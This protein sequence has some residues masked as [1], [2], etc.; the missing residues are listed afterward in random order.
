MK[1]CKICGLRIS[2]YN[3]TGKCWSHSVPAD[4]TG[5]WESV[6]FHGL[7]RDE[8]ATMGAG[9]ECTMIL[10]RAGGICSPGRDPIH[11]DARNS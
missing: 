11:K 1:R 4:A 3:K 2:E 9:M 6:S 7:R 5:D 10:G 8:R